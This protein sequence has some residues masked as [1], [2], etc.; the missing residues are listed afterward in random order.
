MPSLRLLHIISIVAVRT[1]ATV[2]NND[3]G[4]SDQ[5]LYGV[6]YQLYVDQ[7]SGATMDNSADSSIIMKQIIPT[8]PDDHIDFEQLGF[9]TSSPSSE[10]IDCIWYDSATAADNSALNLDPQI[11]IQTVDGHSSA[12]ESESI[13]CDNNGIDQAVH[14]DPRGGARSKHLCAPDCLTCISLMTVD[15]A[16]LSYE[17]SPS[18]VSDATLMVP[19][20]FGISAVLVAFLVV[21]GLS[22]YFGARFRRWNPSKP[23]NETEQ[24]VDE[25]LDEIAKY[26]IGDYDEEEGFDGDSDQSDSSTECDEELGMSILRVISMNQFG[27]EVPNPSLYSSEEEESDEEQCRVDLMV[28]KETLYA[29]SLGSGNPY[30]YD[31]DTAAKQKALQ[32]IEETI[33]ERKVSIN[34]TGCG[35]VGAKDSVRSY[36]H[37]P[38]LS[39]G[40]SSDCK[41]SSSADGAGTGGNSSDLP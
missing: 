12:Q 1:L 4:T 33:V 40:E 25:V 39:G 3:E 10:Q 27:P 5:I 34:R 30:G 35:R 29:A 36:K 21:V 18:R 38:L 2:T 15:N 9:D 19:S 20:M 26:T 23:G 41:V 7:S 8:Q 22:Y 6:C 32:T 16:A 13:V 31:V 11:A 14:I 37:N 24:I 17:H 28:A